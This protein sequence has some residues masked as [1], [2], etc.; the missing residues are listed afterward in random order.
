M[1]NERA[2]Q[3][4]SQRASDEELLFPDLLNHVKAIQ[5]RDFGELP[6]FIIFGLNG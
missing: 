2:T 6:L 1:L 3:W 4:R 5:T